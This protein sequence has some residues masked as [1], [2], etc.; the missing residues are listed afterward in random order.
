MNILHFKKYSVF[1][2]LSIKHTPQ[3]ESNV[4]E[5]SAYHPQLPGRNLEEFDC[6]ISALC[7]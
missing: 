7:K 5:L 4:K 1:Q 3:K 6:G 2:T